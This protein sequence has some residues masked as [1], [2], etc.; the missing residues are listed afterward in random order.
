MKSKKVHLL[1]T[2]IVCTVDA[3][4]ALWTCIATLALSSTIITTASTAD[5]FG[6]RAIGVA[7]FPASGTIVPAFNPQHQYNV[8]EGC[9]NNQSGR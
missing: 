2:L 3:I 7:I 8:G 6:I 1:A 9:C 5:P 4:I